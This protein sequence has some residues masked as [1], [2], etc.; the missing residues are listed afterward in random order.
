MAS[1]A[2]HKKLRQVP[3]ITTSCERVTAIQLQATKCPK[4][5]CIFLFSRYSPLCMT[6][7]T[8]SHSSTLR[9]SFCTATGHQPIVHCLVEVSN[10]RR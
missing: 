10:A 7:R 5:H 4:S 9:I 8:V 2:D 1:Q 3:A 6:S